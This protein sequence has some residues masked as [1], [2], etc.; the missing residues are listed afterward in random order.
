M[1]GIFACIAFALTIPAANFMIGHVGACAPGAP[2][3]IPVGFGLMAPSGVLMIGLA[4]VLRDAV[5]EAWGTIGALAAIAAGAVLSALFAPQALVVA[6][7]LAFTLAE[8]ADLMVYL[9]LRRR[10]LWVAV[11]ASGLVGSIIDSAIFLYVAFGS[12]DF[13]AG[14]VIGK[15]WMSLAAVPAIMFMK[16]KYQLIPSTMERPK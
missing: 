3:V 15:T 5:H 8:L 2:C 9:P 13:I 11:V 4:L 6:S 7:V 1:T 12:L 16:R 10:R 14:N